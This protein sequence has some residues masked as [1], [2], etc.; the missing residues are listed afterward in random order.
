MTLRNKTLLGIVLVTAL[1][2]WCANFFLERY[3]AGKY[4]TREREFLERDI[5]RLLGSLT[6]EKENM[7][8]YITSWAVWDDSYAF[9]ETR[10][11]SFEREQL[12]SISP[13]TM[14][15]FDFYA[16][17]TLEGG[18]AASGRFDRDG[19]S[20]PLSDVEKKDLVVGFSS[21]AKQL[22]NGKGF[23]GIIRVGEWSYFAGA[24][25]ILK[26]DSGGPPRGIFLIGS[27]LAK[28]LPQINSVMQIPV[29]FYDLTSP[30][31][32]P[33]IE[34]RVADMKKTKQRD[35]IDTSDE[36]VANCYIL[37]PE[38]LGGDDFV[39]VLSEARDINK[40]RIATVRSF[41]WAFSALGLV[42]VVILNFVLD[43][44]ILRRLGTLRDI[45]HEIE[46]KGLSGN[47]FPT[48]G[49]DAISTVAGTLNN[50]LDKLEEAEKK[51]AKIAFYDPL[52]RLPNRALFSA[53][54]EDLMRRKEPFSILLMDFDRFAL[55]NEKLGV[56]GADTL[57][58]QAGGMLGQY[59][60]HPRRL[61]RTG[62][63]EF[64]F[65]IPG[66][67]SKDDLVK[68]CRRAQ[69]LIEKPI[70]ISGI[71]TFPSA[72]FGVLMH[73]HMHESEG[74]MLSR[75]QASVRQ[76]KKQGL[77]SVSVYG[78]TDSNDGR[79]TPGDILTYEAQMKDA[80]ARE[81]FV[82]YFQPIYWILGDT[83]NLAGFEALARWDHPGS[84]IITPEY[85][86]P[87]A[88]E[89]GLI[90]AIDR[91]IMTRACRT[92]A[93]WN[94]IMPSLFISVNSSTKD[95]WK[96]DYADFVCRLSDACGVIRNNFVVEI[97]ENALI[98]DFASAAAKM[99]RIRNHGICIALDDFGTGYSSLQYLKQLP[100]DYLKIDQSFVRNLFAPVPGQDLNKNFLLLQGII[101]LSL[102][103]GFG[104]VAEGVETTEHLHW[105][106]ENGCPKGQGFV[107][108]KPVPYEEA[109]RL[110]QESD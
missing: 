99:K 14:M 36:D 45:A 76:A 19:Q 43:K 80:L 59:F 3:V 53:D 31:T 32:P 4:E 12:Q 108:S 89:T 93:E 26:S 55:V 50:T 30:Q 103:L 6:Y 22:E 57:M 66:T 41:S 17:L 48:T 69:T 2:F 70:Q 13:E 104:V 21:L 9:M 90:S 81:Q 83:P 34:N 44:L 37:Q 54:I 95:I 16:L 20:I 39:F 77:S 47:R 40:E 105:L 18:L 94:K 88:E 71:T 1:T 84:G 10:D 101:N 79:R 107:F 24:H 28:R 23:G 109:L 46:E 106:R 85:F 63:D 11:P 92:L 72:S 110:V 65:L 68:M 5:K 64:L 27:L 7:E 86:I 61:Y 98:D 33:E 100:I 62:G 67:Q 56:K 74:N 102:A 78:D 58:E 75:L 97:T 87:Q 42:I 29:D 82:L 51:L 15:A 35:W 73:A 60:N 8:R 38:M 49:N 91:Y 52:T 25:V 96:D